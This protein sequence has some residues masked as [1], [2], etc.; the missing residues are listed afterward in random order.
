MTDNEQQIALVDRAL[1]QRCDANSQR[2]DIIARRMDSLEARWRHFERE[3]QPVGVT[4][5]AN[6]RERA[7]AFYTRQAE[8]MRPMMSR[9]EA[10]DE[11]HWVSEPEQPNEIAKLK[12]LMLEA[13]CIL[14][15][16]QTYIEIEKIM[17]NRLREAA[18]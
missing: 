10:F 2:M 12:E 14:D 17:A 9:E 13:A 3:R 7:R 16:P 11:E 5:P 8:A 1:S 4:S 6:E 15:E 18:K